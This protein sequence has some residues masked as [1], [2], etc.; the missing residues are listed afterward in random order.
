[1]SAD[2]QGND[3][4]A[5]KVPTTGFA[6]IGPVGS[7]LIDP[8]QLKAENLGLPTGFEYLGLFTQDGGP[9]EE[10][11]AGDP[12]EFFQMGYT[13]PSGDDTISETLVLAEDNAAVRRLVYGS[14]GAD[15][16][17]AK[18]GAVPAG[19]FSYLRVTRYKNGT[20]MRRNGIVHVSTIEPEQETRGEVR[21]VSVTFTF[22]YQTFLGVYDEDGHE[23]G[24]FFNDVFID[25]DEPEPE[26]GPGPEPEPTERVYFVCGEDA[27]FAPLEI[28]RTAGASGV[29]V[30]M[31][32]TADETD[33]GEPLELGAVSTT[34]SSVATG[35]ASGT[36]ATLTLVGPGEAEIGIEDATETHSGDLVVTVTGA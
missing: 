19:S 12:L 23:I 8:E 5:V 4:G 26:P 18:T 35:S 11:E 28:T 30:Q 6:A 2:T 22:E 3:L 17:Y 34:A 7:A 33:L 10:N 13:L 21:S 25:R 27:G 9:S 36:T 20:E 24:G 14:E 29:T 31:Y 15:G 1:M 32:W 16:V